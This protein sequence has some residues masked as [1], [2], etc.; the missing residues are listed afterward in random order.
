M[1]HKMGLNAPSFNKIVDGSKTIE[2]RLYDEKRREIKLGDIIEFSKVDGNETI[3]RKVTALLN[4]QNFEALIDC[5]PLS[6][7]G[8][9]NKQ[10]VKKGVNEIYSIEKQNKLSVLGIILAPVQ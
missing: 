9:A 2:L 6:L 8:H 1:V 7:F 3:K 4:F 5:L 10:S